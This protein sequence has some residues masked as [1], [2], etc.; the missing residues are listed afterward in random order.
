MASINKNLLNDWLESNGWV[1]KPDLVTHKFYFNSD[2]IKTDKPVTSSIEALNLQME[3]DLKM[4]AIELP[5]E[6]AYEYAGGN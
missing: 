5:T 1:I 2:T 6:R 3:H 4:K